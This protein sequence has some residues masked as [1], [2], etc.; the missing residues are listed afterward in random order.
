MEPHAI[1]LVSNKVGGEMDEIKTA[2]TW[3]INT[4]TPDRLLAW[5]IDSIIGPLVERSA[6]ALSQVLQAA[7]QTKRARE[8]NKIKS[9][10]TV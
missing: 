5:D 7:A 3:N 10:I 9:C 4:T 2:L 8:N 1:E 6:P